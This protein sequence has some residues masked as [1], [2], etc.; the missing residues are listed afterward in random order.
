MVGEKRGRSEWRRTEVKKF[1]TKLSTG[2]INRTQTDTHT[3]N[4]NSILQPC[5]F[6]TNL[7]GPVRTVGTCLQNFN[8]IAFTVLATVLA[9]NIQKFMWP[10][11]L[12]T[13]FLKIF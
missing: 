3:P 13:L 1:C 12:N 11:P 2:M 7:R 9:L 5:S 10:C 4:E 6:Q 8:S